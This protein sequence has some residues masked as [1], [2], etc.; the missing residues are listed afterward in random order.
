M[1]GTGAS[2]ICGAAFAGNTQFDDAPF[3]SAMFERLVPPEL[4]DFANAATGPSTSDTD[5]TAV[6]E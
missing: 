2:V 6:E 1:A 3:R 4:T 5:R